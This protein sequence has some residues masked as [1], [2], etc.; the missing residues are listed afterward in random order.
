VLG[1]I[2]L[3]GVAGLGYVAL[4]PAGPVLDPRGD[5]P[6]DLATAGE[7]QPYLLGSPEAP[8]TIEEFADYECPSCARFE[9]IT[10]PDVRSRI[11]EAGRA[12]LRYYDLPLPQHRHSY[13]A[14]HAAACADEQGRFWEMKTSIYAAQDRWNTQATSNPRPFFRDMA[15]ALGLDIGQWEQCYDSRKYQNRI[16]ANAAESMRRGVASTPTFI[17]NGQPYRGSINYDD[18]NRAIQTAAAARPASGATGG[19]GGADTA[20]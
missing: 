20:P 5:V 2:V 11:I 4:R 19:S 13:P 18:F 3:A 16:D 15:R 17:I 14:S 8:V 12:N 7:A 9:T 1:A 10:F 6:P